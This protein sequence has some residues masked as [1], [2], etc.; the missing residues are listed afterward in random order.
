MN[1]FIKEQ[2]NK[3]K[4]AIIPKFDENTTQLK[5]QRQGKIDQDLKVGYS[6]IIEL[7]DYIVNPY[8]GFNLHD[9]WN[10]GIVPTDRQ[11][12]I[13]V[14]QEMGKMVKIYGTGMN[15]GQYWSGWVPKKSLKVV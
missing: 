11:M 6:Y 13:C 4:I 2:L 15:D 5:I 9:N 10:N 8:P 12:K 3:C 7:E 1:K 14:E